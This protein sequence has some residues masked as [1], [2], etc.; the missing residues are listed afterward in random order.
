M[1]SEQSKQISF[2][3][4]PIYAR[5]VPQDH[6]LRKISAVID[7]K[8][9]N[10]LCKDLYCPDNGRP[11]WEP[12]LLFKVLFLQFL[13]NLS[14]REI[15]SELSD[16]MSFKCFLG[17]PVDESVPDYS[18]LSKFR[19]RLGP[20]R[21]AKIF[22]QI[23]NVARD[24][25]LVSDKLH[26][27]DATD[28]KAKVDQFRITD[29]IKKNEDKNKN[30]DKDDN[31]K[32]SQGKFET[33]DA[34][35]R[36]GRKSDSKKFYGYK[37]HLRMD[38]ESGIIVGCKT[39]PGNESDG[40]QLGDLLSTAP[41]PGVL[42][43]DKGYDSKENHDLLAKNH[44]R[45]GIILK[46]NHT[47][48]YTCPKRKSKVAKKFRGRIE[49]K[50]SEYKNIHDFKVAR[51]WGLAK[52]SVQ[53]YLTGIVVNCKRIIRLLEMLHDPPRIMLRTV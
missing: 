8:F 32:Q 12:Q 30:N 11:C 10:D 28:V 5:T 46:N 23:V 13:Y 3:D 33:P 52:V 6:F 7:F 34:D 14:D 35:A 24:N 36:F 31:D 15:E 20:E 41:P 49:P 18:M 17:L 29:E 37:E 25:K 21:F 44:I 2:Y 45:N 38:A 26:I 48:F 53:A 51:Y 27:V 47:K 39:T 50:F 43:A 4:E 9:V 40:S 22:N 16:R 1:Y 42:T 19:D